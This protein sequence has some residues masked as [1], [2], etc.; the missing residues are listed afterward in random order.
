M[1]QLGILLCNLIYTLIKVVILLIANYEFLIL[2]FMTVTLDVYTVD[3]QSCQLVVTREAVAKD[4]QYHVMKELGLPSSN[5]QLCE[6][7]SSGGMI[8]WLWLHVVNLCIAIHTEFVPFH[9]MEKSLDTSLS[10]NGRIFILPN[11]FSGR[12]V[13]DNNTKL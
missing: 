1:L 12:V 7:K 3:H 2:I 5:Y 13:N 8:T 10:V 9:E 4:I 6:V 11:D